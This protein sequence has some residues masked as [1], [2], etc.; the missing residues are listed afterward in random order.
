VHKKFKTHSDENISW[1]EF[2]CRIPFGPDRGQRVRLTDKEKFTVR[3]IYDRE[4]KDLNFRSLLQDGNLAAYIVLLHLCGP[5]ALGNDPPEVEADPWTVWHSAG[6]T[7]H[8]FLQR[9]GEVVVCRR[10]RTRYPAAA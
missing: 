1:I 4:A 6:V 9:E 2:H 7:L 8:R 5:M 3:Q 10:L